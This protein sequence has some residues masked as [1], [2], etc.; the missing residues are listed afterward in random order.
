MNRREEV[1]R[2]IADHLPADPWET[3]SRR[4]ALALLRWLSDPL[5]RDADPTHVTGS[6]IVVSE[7]GRVLM[8]RHRRLGLW[9]QPGGHLE[10]GEMPADAAVRETLEETG[11]RAHH[12]SGGPALVHVDLHEGPGA[13]L[14]LDLRYRLRASPGQPI[15]P[16]MGESRAVAWLQPEEACAR[17]D[18][19]LVAA[20]E[21]ALSEGRWRNG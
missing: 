6:A 3:N 13:H 11:I 9:L 10:P 15:A 8:H 19:S 1:L 14:H 12:P 18:R 16:A 5:D 20:V 4:R 21:A 2:S 7:D 17:G